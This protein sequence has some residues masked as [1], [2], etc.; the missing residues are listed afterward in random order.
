MSG[1]DVALKG[2]QGEEDGV[3]EGPQTS[4]AIILSAT[5]HVTASNEDSAGNVLRRRRN[6]P[7]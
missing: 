4:R 1:S 3:E 2:H 5:I 6:Q 7:E